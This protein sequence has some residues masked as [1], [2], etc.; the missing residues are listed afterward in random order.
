MRQAGRYLPEYRRVR[1]R[2]ED[3]LRFCYTPDLAVE[4]TLQPWHRYG[5]DGVILFSDILVV[6]DALGQAVRLG[7]LSWGYPVH[8]NPYPFAVRICP[9][10]VYSMIPSEKNTHRSGKP[11]S[12][13]V[14]KAIYFPCSHVSRNAKGLRILC[15]H[16]PTPSR[17]SQPFP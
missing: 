2:A 5:M 13:I 14:S 7:G 15:F 3:F 11:G 16:G 12:K 10:S 6:P 8:T 9:I 1:E 4:V 17:D